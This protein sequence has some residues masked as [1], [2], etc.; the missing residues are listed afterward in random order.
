[1]RDYLHKKFN[2]PKKITC[3][4]QILI[5]SH[6]VD[7][8]YT[9]TEFECFFCIQISQNEFKILKHSE[10]ETKNEGEFF[11]E[12]NIKF[13]FPIFHVEWLKSFGG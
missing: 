2:S 7:Q 11:S 8:N 3:N 1:M 9:S 12:K 4:K 5:G 6:I 13:H 10:D